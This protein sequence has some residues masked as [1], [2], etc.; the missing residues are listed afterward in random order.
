VVPVSG[1]RTL[2]EVA[3]L[4]G[5]MVVTTQE[6]ML[7]VE[8]NGQV[9]NVAKG[10]TITV[11]PS[12]SAPQGGGN[13]PSGHHLS[14]CCVWGVVATAVSAAGLVLAAIAM[15]RANTAENNASTAS[16]N[17][18]AATSAANAAASAANAAAS[19]DAASENALGCALNNLATQEGLPSP[20]TPTA[21]CPAT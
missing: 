2:G 7:R 1:F 21:P 5:T 3:T 14:G 11:Y 12:A 13:P 6:G 17:A 15:S 16:S 10:K 9:A 18:A 8:G 4:N 19:A 20:W